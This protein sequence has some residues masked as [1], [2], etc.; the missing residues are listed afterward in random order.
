MAVVVSILM[1]GGGNTL[2]GG[3]GGT[4]GHSTNTPV[5]CPAILSRVRYSNL[6][7]GG[8]PVLCSSEAKN[9]CVAQ[10]D[11]GSVKQMTVDKD[12]EKGRVANFL[13]TGPSCV[14]RS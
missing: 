12:R 7:G 11:T 3:Q 5:V 13:M 14:P 8:F 6:P 1:G 2:P 10:W 9:L 4:Q